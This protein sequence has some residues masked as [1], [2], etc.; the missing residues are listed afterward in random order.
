M[1]SEKFKDELAASN[2][3]LNF[4]TTQNSS[5]AVAAGD[6]ISVRGHGK[7]RIEDISGRTSKDKIRLMAV[8]YK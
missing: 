1:P 5:A 2:V 4:I 8:K 6:V 3:Q 7:Y